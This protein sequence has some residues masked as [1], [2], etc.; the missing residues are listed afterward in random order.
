MNPDDAVRDS[1]IAHIDAASA[2]LETQVPVIQLA[3]QRLARCLLDESRIFA[4][5][6]AGS[7]VL[8]QHLTVKLLGRLERERPGL[9]IFCL[10]DN[11]PLLSALVDHFGAHDIFARQVRALGQPGDVL[12]TIAAG[13]APASTMQAIIAA[14]D[15]GMDVIVFSGRD[16]DELEHMLADNDIEIRVASSSPMRTEEIHLLLLNVVCDILEREL[17]GEMT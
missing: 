3:A 11:A 15:R 6:N 4:C 12:V 5:G 13:A 1:L 16:N 10:T 7:A 8:A 14:H 2:A 17:F 9:P